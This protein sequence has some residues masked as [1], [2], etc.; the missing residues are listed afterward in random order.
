MRTALKGM[1][2]TGLLLGLIA[3]CLLFAPAS[4]E[5]GSVGEGGGSLGEQDVRAAVETWVRH[6]TADARPDAVVEQMEPHKVDG[7]TV[8][9]IAHLQGGGYCLAGADP[10][11]LP[12]YLYSP[13]GTYDPDN[14]SYQFILWEIGARLEALRQS[15]AERAPELQPYQE[16]LSERALYWQDLIAGR[17]LARAEDAGVGTEPAMMELDLTSLWDQG[18]PYN[19]QCPELTPGVDEH[20]VVGCTA[21]AM[22]QIMRYWQWP[23]T[24]VGSHSTTYY[25]R[26]R[27]NW[28]DEGPVP[29]DPGIPAGWV[30]TGRLDWTDAGGGTLWMNG[31]WDESLYKTARTFGPDQDYL[32]ALSALYG[33]LTPA[34]TNCSANFGATTYDW[35]VLQDVHR[36]P[37]D[38]GDPEVAELSYHAGVAADMYYGLHNSSAGLDAAA[39]ALATYFRYDSDAV[40]ELR[41][42]NTKDK[43]I[44]DIQWLRPAELE[45]WGVGRGH[46]WVAYGYKE[47]T[48]QFLMNMG[49]YGS[50]DDWYTLDSVA[51]DPGPPPFP[52]YAV[53]KHVT[54]IA[55]LDVVRFVG[56]ANP[57]DGSPDDPHEDI[58]EAIS[59]APDGATLIFKA[60]SDNTFSAST[61]TIDKPL[62]LKGKDVTIRKQ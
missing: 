20:V 48:D 42:A 44:E 12:V 46:A 16:A 18:S 19:D 15:L 47:S 17:I 34:T 4:P 49:S 39:N 33:R 37:V 24:G 8:A 36:D 32:D 53:T 58:E 62:T 55:P 28:D 5:A 61:L 14:P 45:G 30:A 21:T 38:N 23:N 52:G 57:G 41:D 43:L 31:Y 26:W 29:N 35:S 27:N 10:L 56:A 59:D 60:G 9:Y 13:E 2:K 54:R 1:S 6:V 7:E 40:A 3:L 25:W 22:A 50:S 51:P 11:V